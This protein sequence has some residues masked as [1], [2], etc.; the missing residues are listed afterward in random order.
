[1][2]TH[3]TRTA[4]TQG[5]LCALMA[6]DRGFTLVEILVA[7]AVF[8]VVMTVVTAIFVSGLHTRAEGVANLALERDGTLMLEQIVRGLYGTRGLREADKGSLLIS[9]GGSSIR[10]AVD[11]NAYPTTTKGDD[12]TSLVYLLE[13]RVYYKPN[14]GA[15]VIECI[16][17]SDSDVESLLF[18]P[19]QDG[20]TI[21]VKLTSSLPATNRKAFIHLTKSVTMRN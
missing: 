13:G 11:R 17:G 15:E 5:T 3:Q 6:S 20:V 21:S 18:T 8:V 7:I 2:L 19:T 9:N 16:S 10:F 4:R 14:V 1:M 12:D